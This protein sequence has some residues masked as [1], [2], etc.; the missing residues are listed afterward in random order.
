MKGLRVMGSASL[1]VLSELFPSTLHSRAHTQLGLRTV[2]FM[3]SKNWNKCLE[4]YCTQ[5]SMPVSQVWV[6]KYSQKAITE[7]HKG[8]SR[9]GI[10]L[11]NPQQS[12]ADGLTTSRGT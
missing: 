9:N 1:A 6:F 12:A 4:F 3:Y 7:V 5:A 11:W 8:G 10:F 2:S